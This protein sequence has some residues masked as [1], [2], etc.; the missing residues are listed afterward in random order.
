MPEN[1]AN[2]CEISIGLR[3]DV[4]ELKESIG[5]ATQDV[6]ELKQISASRTVEV[7]N[8]AKALDKFEV[9]LKTMLEGIEGISIKIA[10]LDFY[11][12]EEVDKKIDSATIKMK[13]DVDILK[14]KPA[15]QWDKLVEVVVTAL[16][17]AIIGFLIANI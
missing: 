1:C 11:T 12:R 17:G 7:A 5:I 8:L 13:E 6:G 9:T 4:D 16:V 14:M 2:N 10:T 15:K 3:R